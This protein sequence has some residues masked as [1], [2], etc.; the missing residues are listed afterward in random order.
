MTLYHICDG[1]RRAQKPRGWFSGLGTDDKWEHLFDGTD[2][3]PACVEAR[4]KKQTDEMFAK[5]RAD[6][7]LALKERKDD[8]SP[9]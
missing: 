2:Y 9:S 5:I 7:G 8:G 6:F 1:C 3:C 4:Q